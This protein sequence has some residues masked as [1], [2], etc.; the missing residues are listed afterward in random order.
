MQFRYIGEEYSEIFGFKW[1]S[2]TVHDVTDEHA[3]KKLSGSALFEAV[4]DV[5]KPRAPE[6]EPVL[7]DEFD[8]LPDEEPVAEPAPKKKGGR[9]R[10]EV[11]ID[12]DPLT[13]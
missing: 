11:V 13:D 5:A 7:V 6:P 1:M 12:D 10:K 3:V 4:T 2:G 9:S 8:D